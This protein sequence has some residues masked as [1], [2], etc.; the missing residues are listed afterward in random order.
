VRQYRTWLAVAGIAA[1]ASGLVG[2]IGTQARAQQTVPAPDTPAQL[3]ADARLLTA[4]QKVHLTSSQAGQAADALLVLAEAADKAG[5]DESRLLD[6]NAAL[7]TSVR[8]GLLSG[9]ELDPAVGLAYEKLARDLGAVRAGRSKAQA[10]CARVLGG[11]LTADQRE[12]A[13]RKVRSG[14]P[15]AGSLRSPADLLRVVRQW[16]DE[17][18]ATDRASVIERIAGKEATD[19][20]RGKVAALLDEARALDGEQFEARREALTQ[21]LLALRAGGTGAAAGGDPFGAPP[22]PGDAPG[23]PDQRAQSRVGALAVV[24]MVRKLDDATYQQRKPALASR[25]LKR[26]GG[27]PGN[28]AA[29]DKLGALLD[30]VRAI[31]EADLRAAAPDLGRK[32]AEVLPGLGAAHADARDGAPEPG[33]NL[34]GGALVRLAMV[35][36]PRH[37]ADLMREYAE[38]AP[39]E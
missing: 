33:S 39:R 37:V 11:L 25:L 24:K 12:M 21:E 26:A 9:E 14:R 2:A 7:L 29:L 4:L 34:V 15:G 1:L 13:A 18:Y 5:A 35:G 20:T 8:T 27:D 6:D 10:E 19:E 16:T 3:A 23:R 17:A 30:E 38:H 31:P 32:L 36:D 22:A 28:Q